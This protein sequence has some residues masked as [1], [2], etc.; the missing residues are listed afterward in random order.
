MFPRPIGYECFYRAVGA[1]TSDWRTTL[2]QSIRK[3][4]ELVKK[5][6]NRI[7]GGLLWKEGSEGILPV[8]NCEGAHLRYPS[9]FRFFFPDVLP[10]ARRVL[11]ALQFASGDLC[12]VCLQAYV[13]LYYVFL[14]FRV[15]V[16]VT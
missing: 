10:R 8:G 11:L 13:F 7:T 5:N 14:T 16:C 12:A 4:L 15:Y 1:E 9:L 3:R 2:N 6:G